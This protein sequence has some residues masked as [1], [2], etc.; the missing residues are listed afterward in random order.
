[1]SFIELHFTEETGLSSRSDLSASVGNAVRSFGVTSTK[2]INRPPKSCRCHRL[3][4]QGHYNR[5]LLLD[6]FLDTTDTAKAGSMSLQGEPAAT[7]RRCG[8]IG[9]WTMP[10][11]A[12]NRPNHSLFVGTLWV[13]IGRMLIVVRVVPI[14]DPLPDVPGHILHSVG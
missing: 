6:R 11:P 3:I 2:P 1:M 14:G 10:G 4:S 9:R 8:D 12:T 7:A 5:L 13:P